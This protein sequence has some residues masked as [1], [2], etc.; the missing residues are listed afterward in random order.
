MAGTGDR[1]GAHIEGAMPPCSRDGRQ[2][3]LPRMRPYE[4]PGI[5]RAAMEGFDPGEHLPIDHRRSMA[6]H[7]IGHRTAFIPLGIRSLLA[8]RCAGGRQRKER[9]CRHRQERSMAVGI[10]LAEAKLCRCQPPLS[11]RRRRFSQ[12]APGKWRCRPAATCGMNF[13]PVRA[14]LARFRMAIEVAAAMG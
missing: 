6:S 11:R 4:A 7:A 13:R 12:G 8:A 14:L 9:H 3:I 10:V 2:M 5:S 1:H